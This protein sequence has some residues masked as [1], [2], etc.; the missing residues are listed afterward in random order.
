MLTNSRAVL[1]V[2]DIQ[3]KLAESMYERD[4]LYRNLIIMIEG[5][6]ALGLPILC[7]EQYPEGL[8]PTVPEIASHLEGYDCIA[9]KS[10]S[11]LRTPTF[12][13]RFAGLGRDQVIMTGIETH[14]CIHQTSIDF[15]ARDIETHVVADAVS[16]RTAFN[17]SI[18]LDKI[19]R[20]GGIITS[21]ETALFEM[22]GVAEG[23]TFK[24][25]SKLVK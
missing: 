7:V 19:A 10:F 15:I 16:S 6:K 12:E 8:G 11:S 2:T 22:L 24:K 21:A 25:I 9:K 14:V 1:I 20:A 13:R 3:G 23:G 18:G 17:K 4:N 5:A